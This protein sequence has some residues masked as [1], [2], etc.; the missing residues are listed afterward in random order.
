[1]DHTYSRQSGRPEFKRRPRMVGKKPEDI[2][3]KEVSFFF[4]SFTSHDDLFFV[5]GFVKTHVG[6]G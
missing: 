5:A 2:A 3:S 1:M 4:S 6:Q